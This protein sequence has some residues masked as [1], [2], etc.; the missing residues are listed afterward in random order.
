VRLQFQ[1]VYVFTSDRF[2]GNPLA[3]ALSAEDLSTQQMQAIAAEFNLAETTF[4]RPPFR[5][6]RRPGAPM[7]R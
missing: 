2:A 5:K 3:L 1:T 6:T 4:V 7:S